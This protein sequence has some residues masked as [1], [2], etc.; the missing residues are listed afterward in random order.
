MTHQTVPVHVTALEDFL[1]ARSQQLHQTLGIDGCKRISSEDVPAEDHTEGQAQ[2]TSGTVHGISSADM[3][4]RSPRHLKLDVFLQGTA[5]EP[6]PA[7]P[8]LPERPT[9]SGRHAGGLGAARPGCIR[10]LVPP[11]ARERAQ[12]HRCCEQP[13]LGTEVITD[14][15]QIDIGCCRHQLM[16]VGLWPRRRKDFRAAERMRSLAS[17]SPRGLPRVFFII[18]EYRRGVSLCQQA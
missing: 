6:H 13:S 15:G 7:G 4:C 12:C 14:Q 9:P 16:V 1:K 8:R 17:D 11:P 3:S 2:C 5:E 10:A 18:D